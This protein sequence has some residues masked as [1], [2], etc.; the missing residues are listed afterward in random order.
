MLP[1]F[2][3]LFSFHP[4]VAVISC[5]PL[6][7][8]LTAPAPSIQSVSSVVSCAPVA[9]LLFVS[10]GVTSLVFSLDRYVLLVFSKCFHSPITGS[11]TKFYSCGVSVKLHNT[12]TCIGFGKLSVFRFS[13]FSYTIIFDTIFS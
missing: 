12:I 4:S 8:L 5:S 6:P 13:T 11:G 2:A 10:L 1:F 7:L 9:V 3:P